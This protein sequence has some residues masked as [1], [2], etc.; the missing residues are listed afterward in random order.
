VITP[1]HRYAV[2]G[3]VVKNPTLYPH[4]SNPFRKYCRLHVPVLHPISSSCTSF[5]DV[6]QRYAIWVTFPSIFLGLL[7]FKRQFKLFVEADK[8]EHEC[9]RGWPGSIPMGISNSECYLPGSMQVS[10]TGWLRSHESKTRR[11]SSTCGSTGTWK[12]LQI[13][14]ILNR[15]EELN[16]KHKY[17]VEQILL[18]HQS[19]CDW[20]QIWLDQP[21]ASYHQSTLFLSLPLPIPH[22]K[23]Q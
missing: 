19:H 13:L 8:A 4:L 11:F 12:Y 10:A 3:G 6:V 16:C 15:N 7:T 20:N 2:C 18:R 5:N 17:Y 1:W 23:H 9:T 22:Q 14:S 21:R